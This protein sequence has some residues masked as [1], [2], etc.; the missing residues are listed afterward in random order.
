MF[1]F[2]TQLMTS[3][4]GRAGA[5]TSHGFRARLERLESR[6]MLSV[7]AIVDDFA[8]IAEESVELDRLPKAD[9]EM[10]RPGFDLPSIIPDD[11]PWKSMPSGPEGGLPYIPE[12]ELPFVPDEGAEHHDDDAD[13]GGMVDLG[14]TDQDEATSPSYGGPG[15]ESD[16]DLYQDR[17]SRDVLSMLAGL[18]YHPGGLD[19]G[20]PA[21]E[22][23]AAGDEWESLVQDTAKLR[24]D[25]QQATQGEG[26]VIILAF[27]EIVDEL[28]AEREAADVDVDALLDVPVQMDASS[29]RFRAFEVLTHESAQVAPAVAESEAVG[30]TSEPSEGVDLV[31]ADVPTTG[32]IRPQK[33]PRVDG[34]AD[35]AAETITGTVVP[36]SILAPAPTDDSSKTMW[37]SAVALVTGGL[38]VQLL[39]ERKFEQLSAR[40]TRVYRRFARTYFRRRRKANAAAQR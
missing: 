2:L 21:A 19:S 28:A 12:E 15:D 33:E 5:P 10:Q 1:S 7:A 9:G 40:A 34:N 32:T 14:A 8:R 38:V 23:V 37:T 29:G 6:C 31:K 11:D 26:G 22:E 18:R 20:L 17:E 36:L 24:N 16:I 4:T 13:E 30:A 27:D 25:E 35:D 3:R 39:R